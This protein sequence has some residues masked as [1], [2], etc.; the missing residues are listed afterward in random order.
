MTLKE[1]MKTIPMQQREAFAC[2]CGTTLNYLNMVR[3][4]AK[5]ANKSLCMAIEKRSAGAVRCEE[6]RPDI[7]WKHIEDWALARKAA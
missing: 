6:L 3:C 1:F 7:E 4:G 5:K 2:E